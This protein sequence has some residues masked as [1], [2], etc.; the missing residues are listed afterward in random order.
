LGEWL[1]LALRTQ[2]HITHAGG[3]TNGAFSLSLERSLINGWIYSVSVQKVTDVNGICYEGIGIT[4][5]YAVTNTEEEI[6][7]NKDA[8][9]EYARDLF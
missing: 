8:Q 4:P 2:D 5:E 3:T 9:L 1:T 7:A 6:A